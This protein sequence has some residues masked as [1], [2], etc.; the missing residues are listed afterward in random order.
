MPVT[1]Y[2]AQVLTVANTGAG[3]IGAD[4][5]NGQTQIELVQSADVDFAISRQDVFEFGNLYAVDNI[6][7]EPATVT[8]NFSYALSSGNGVTPTNASKLGMNNFDTFL[9]EQGRNY[10]ISG[11]GTLI[12]T[13]GIVKTYSVDGSVGNIPTVSVSVDA[14]NATYTAGNPVFKGDPGFSGT[15]TVATIIQPKDITVQIGTGAQGTNPTYEARSFTFALDIPRNK[16]NRLGTLTPVANILAGPPK[17]A[18]DTEIIL[19]GTQNPQFNPNVPQN[20]RIACGDKNFQINNA[21]LANFTVTNTLD[22]I[23]VCSIALEAPVTGS[24]AIV[25][26]GESGA[27]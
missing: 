1:Y 22:D 2:P 4:G 6:Q 20:V 13:S 15:T 26:E 3:G 10:G 23:Q 5:S 21:K 7:V 8:L 12:I 27:P 14:I 16:I 19:N 17:V 25:I 24:D 9:N 11:A 18:L